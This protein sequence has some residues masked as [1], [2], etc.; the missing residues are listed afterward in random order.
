MMT[1]GV[2]LLGFSLLG[3]MEAGTEMSP[4]ME[5]SPGTEEPEMQDMDSGM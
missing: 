4:E 5:M 3:G 2:V 1:G